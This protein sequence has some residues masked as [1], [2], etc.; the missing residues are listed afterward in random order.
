[1][2]TECLRYALSPL[3][4]RESEVVRPEGPA[5]NSRARKVVDKGLKMTGEVRRTGIIMSA[6]R[7]LLLINGCNP[8]LTVGAIQWRRF[9]PGTA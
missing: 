8:D 5:L 4:Q 1:M 3:S 6:L 9:A 2:Q 7:A